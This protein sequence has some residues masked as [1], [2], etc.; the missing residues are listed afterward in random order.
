[1]TRS[2]FDE[3]RNAPARHR[4]A[5]LV[6]H[7]A[8]DSEPGSTEAGPLRVMPLFDQSE[9]VGDQV[10]GPKPPDRESNDQDEDRNAGN[11]PDQEKITP[12][13]L[14][15]RWRLDTGLASDADRTDTLALSEDG[16]HN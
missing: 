8:D 9:I 6:E 4:M 1:M 7:R 10:K 5:H 3:N 13:F 14:D 15:H 12:D 16:S 2:A 11:D